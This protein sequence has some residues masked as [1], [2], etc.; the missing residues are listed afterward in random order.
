MLLI[1]HP[2][3]RTVIV[4]ENVYSLRENKKEKWK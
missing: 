3:G 4:A 1:E 2:R